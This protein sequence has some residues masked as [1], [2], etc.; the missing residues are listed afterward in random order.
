MLCLCQ[1]VTIHQLQLVCF[2]VFSKDLDFDGLFSPKISQ[3]E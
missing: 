2:D 1:T 3:I